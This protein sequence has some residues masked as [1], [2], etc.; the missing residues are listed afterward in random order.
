V[1][2]IAVV[3]DS[4]DTL[5][6]V[7]FYLEYHFRLDEVLTFLDGPSFL[8]SHRAKAMDLTILDISM[9]KMDGF[10]V[11]EQLRLID[12]NVLVIGLSAY[13]MAAERE[14]ALAAGC[15]EYVTKPVLDVDGFCR[16]VRRHLPIEIPA[17]AKVQTAAVPSASGSSAED[18]A[19]A[20]G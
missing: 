18:T 1:A 16:I 17:T 8:S 3:D 10:E 5:Q 6:I 12:P 20:C 7:R 2:K 14:R 4:E 15:C 9:P 11:L 13:A 19:I